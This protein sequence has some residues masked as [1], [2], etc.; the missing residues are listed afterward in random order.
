MYRIDRYNVTNYGAVYHLRPL[1][2]HT[3]LTAGILR[4]VWGMWYMVTVERV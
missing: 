2:V 3:R 1:Y 4:A